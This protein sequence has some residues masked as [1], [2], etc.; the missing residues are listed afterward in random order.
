MAFSHHRLNELNFDDVD[1]ECVIGLLCHE[2]ITKL[3]AKA[4]DL[5]N[6]IAH[7]G[8]PSA[9]LVRNAKEAVQSLNERMQ[10]ELRAF[11]EVTTLIKPVQAKYDG[12]TFVHE[13]EILKGLGINPAKTAIIKTS[14]PMISGEL[15]LTHSELNENESITVTKLFPLLTMRET[16][17]N[18]EIMG[19]Y[20]YSDKV[21]DKLRFV[22]PY[23]NV[24]TYKFLPENLIRESL[25][26]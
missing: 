10:I 5:R 4:T 18:S 24:E 22:C 3:L 25:N 19:F 7:R 8:L 23:P 11:F 20:F 9:E 13:V 2:K 26:D 15:Y 21:E 14:E 12:N 6:D 17:Q 1:S 16:V